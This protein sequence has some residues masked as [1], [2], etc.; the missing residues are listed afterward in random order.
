VVS[1][2]SGSCPL[3]MFRNRKPTKYQLGPAPRAQTLSGCQQLRTKGLA[4][5]PGKHPQHVRPCNVFADTGAFEVP[6]SSASAGRIGTAESNCEQHAEAPARTAHTT[7]ACARCAILVWRPAR[8]VTSRVPPRAS[9]LA[10]HATLRLEPVRK[11]LTCERMRTQTE[12]ACSTQSIRTDRC[13][14]FTFS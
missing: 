4:E 1:Y 6:H 8:A 3:R 2:R 12:N 7:R 9:S 14:V 11:T 10:Y 13:A 5:S